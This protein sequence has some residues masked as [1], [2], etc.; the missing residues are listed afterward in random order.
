MDIGTRRIRDRIKKRFIPIT[1]MIET[2]KEE[3][4]QYLDGET[5]WYDM[6]YFS[7]VKLRIPS[8]VTYH[9]LSSTRIQNSWIMYDKLNY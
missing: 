9:S 1:E 5:F 4:V 6:L 8:M 7:R 2:A 3:L